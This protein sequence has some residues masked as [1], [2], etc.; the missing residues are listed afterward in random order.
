MHPDGDYWDIDDIL[1]EH[2]VRKASGGLV[3]SNDFITYPYQANG[4]LVNK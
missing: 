2:Q 1:A 3:M 4:N